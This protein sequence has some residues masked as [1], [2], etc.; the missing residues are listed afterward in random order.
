MHPGMC[1]EH[2]FGNVE[3]SRN[4]GGV[5]LQDSDPCENSATATFGTG[6]NWEFVLLG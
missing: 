5:T 1:G 3:Q 4:L 2:Y 6:F